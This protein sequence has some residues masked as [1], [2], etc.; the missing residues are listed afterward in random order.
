MPED[1]HLGVLFGH[2]RTVVADQ[3]ALAAALGYLHL[4][5][6][7]VGIEGVLAELLDHGGG[8]VDDLA[9]G[10]LLCHEGIEQRYPA[11][12]TSARRLHTRIILLAESS[13]TTLVTARDRRA[14][15]R[16]HDWG[17]GGAMAKTG[18]PVTL[19]LA[20]YDVDGTLFRHGSIGRAY[21]VR[22]S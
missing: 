14:R 21:G 17:Y 2:A 13:L 15:P 5:A 22:P 18:P 12:E 9:G 6:G 11:Q 10:D 19:L 16:R 4:H 20:V 7:A 3:H 1:A 8:P